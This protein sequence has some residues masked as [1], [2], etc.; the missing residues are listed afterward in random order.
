MKSDEQ[1]QQ[2]VMDELKWEPSIHAAQIGVEVHDGV[3]TLAGEVGSYPEKWSA[4]QVVLRVAGVKALAVNLKVKL[5]EPGQRADA[6]IA[7]SAQNTLRW[8]MSVPQDAVKVLVENGWL[9][10]SGDVEWQY[11]RQAAAEAVRHLHGVT[12]VSNQIGIK[13]PISARVVKADKVARLLRVARAGQLDKAA[14]DYFPVEV[15]KAARRLEETLVARIKEATKPMVINR[16]V[17]RTVTKRIKRDPK[18][19]CLS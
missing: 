7:L 4:E 11:Q 10:L 5:S 13:P 14:E 3:V 6:D 9:V 2:D 16:M 15:G 17:L 8:S 19:K 18:T 1:V 12:G